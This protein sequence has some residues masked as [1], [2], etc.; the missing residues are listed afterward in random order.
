M[1]TKIFGNTPRLPAQLKVTGKAKKYC[2]YRS[3]SASAERYVGI[4]NACD[5]RWREEHAKVVR[6]FTPKLIG[7]ATGLSKGQAQAIE[8]AC[9]V[10]GG[11]SSA[12]GHLSNQRSIHPSKPY[13]A[14]AVRYGNALLKKLGGTCPVHAAL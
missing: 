5:R 11:L 1:L 3:T 12:G 9:I 8:Q 6:A 2:V 10:A 14:K 7:E 4:S 13:Y